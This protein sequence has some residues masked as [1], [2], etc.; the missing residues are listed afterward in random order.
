MLLNESKGSFGIEGETPPR[1][2]LER[3]GRLIADAGDLELSAASL[4][5]LHRSLFD[6]RRQRFLTHGLRRI[7][8]FVG[9]HDPRA[10]TPVH[11]PISANQTERRTP[12]APLSQPL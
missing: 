5:A 6:P 1:N 3:W 10:Q 12:L 8:G 9:R 4:E 2:R 7:A 11:D